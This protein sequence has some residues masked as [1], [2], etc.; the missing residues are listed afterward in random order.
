[1]QKTIFTEKENTSIR[2]SLPF[3]ILLLFFFTFPVQGQDRDAG[4]WSALEVE[5]G[6]NKWLDVQANLEVR[7]DNN[8][9]RAER[10][11]AEIGLTADMGKYFDASL[12]YRYTNRYFPEYNRV[13]YSRVYADVRFNYDYMAFSFYERV[14]LTFDEIPPFFEDGLIETTARLKTQ[15]TYNIRKTPLRARGSVEFFFPVTHSFNPYVEKT[16]YKLG[17]IYIVNQMVSV[18]AG[19]MFQQV[20]VKNKPQNNF[21]WV[22]TLDY[23]F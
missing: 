11:L 2:G 19:H 13:S 10:Y 23:T 6:I 1:M 7:L 16:R 8:I 14:R 17:M 9:S 4:L 18:E 15:A 20:T 3:I 22:V 5:K 21:I 12:V